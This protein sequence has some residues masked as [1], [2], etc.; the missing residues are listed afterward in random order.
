MEFLLLAW[1][2]FG[3]VCHVAQCEKMK[4]RC[5]T[6]IWHEP[7]TYVMFIPAMVAGPLMLIAIKLGSTE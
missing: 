6:K 1:P 7:S 3:A 2:I 5:G 4:T